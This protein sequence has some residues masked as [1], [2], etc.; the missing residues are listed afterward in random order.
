M[1]IEII[2][3]TLYKVVPSSEVGAGL[4]AGVGP[5]YGGL[6][7]YVGCWDGTQLHQASIPQA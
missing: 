1:N 4:W 7:V 5:R 6:V 3:N 2:R